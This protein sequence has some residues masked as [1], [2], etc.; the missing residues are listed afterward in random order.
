MDRDSERR[1]WL[2]AL[3]QV[4]I[5][6]PLAWLSLAVIAGLAVAAFLAPIV[7]MVRWLWG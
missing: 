5:V 7:M 1:D 2:L 6:P 4:V 3:W